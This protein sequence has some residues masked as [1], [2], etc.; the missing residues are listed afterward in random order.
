MRSSPQ[1]CLTGCMAGLRFFERAEVKHALAYMRLLDNPADDGAFLR[2]VNFPAR[3]IGARSLEMLQDAARASGTSLYDAASRISGAAGVKLAGFVGLIEKMR[4]D[5]AR[6]S[7][8]ELVEHLTEVSGLMAHYA[9]EKEGQ[10]RIEN[11][12]ELVNA[13]AAFLAEEG[14]AQDLPSSAGL[15][16]LPAEAK[17][18]PSSC[19]QCLDECRCCARARRGHSAD[20]IGCIPLACKPGGRRESGRR[21]RNRDPAHDG[22][23]GQGSG[24]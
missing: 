18:R 2:V 14:V 19:G 3:G 12:R 6:L 8:K 21:G 24:V 22:A 5:T 17:L 7:L 4:R 11:L 16:Q 13:A 1:V 20:P 23:L 9:V 15:N 10:E